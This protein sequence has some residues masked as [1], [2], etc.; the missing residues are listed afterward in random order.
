M[1]TLTIGANFLKQKLDEFSTIEA[2]NHLN[3]TPNLNFTLTC[4]NL[5]YIIGV[6]RVNFQAKCKNGI[7][8]TSIWVYKWPCIDDFPLSKMN[9]EISIELNYMNKSNP[10]AT[11][12]F[13]FFFFSNSSSQVG[14]LVRIPNINYH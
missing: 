10:N 12:V 5:K 13:F 1:A 9:F 4:Y 7:I 11:R 8:W 6:S 2:N 3:R 14:P